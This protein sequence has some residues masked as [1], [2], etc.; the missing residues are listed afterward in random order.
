M[1]DYVPM[2]GPLPG[3]RYM[4]SNGTEGMCFQE[5]WCCECAKDNEM[6]GSC[7]EEGR[8]ATDEDYCPILNAS[9]R[10]EAEEWRELPDGRTVCIAF[11]KRAPSNDAL[12]RCEHTQELF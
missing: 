1:A 12:P 4:P 11:Q 5:A 3:E 6:N 9:Y 2:A 8:D 10:D 7:H